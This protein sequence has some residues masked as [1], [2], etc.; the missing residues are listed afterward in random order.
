MSVLFRRRTDGGRWAL[1]GTLPVLARKGN[2]RLAHPS[3][4]WARHRYRVRRMERATRRAAVFDRRWAP[5]QS[6]W[7]NFAGGKPSRAN[8]PRP[9]PDPK[10]P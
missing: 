4:L 9:K 6:A 2:L 3:P 5:V 8:P 7:E 1:Q 10:K